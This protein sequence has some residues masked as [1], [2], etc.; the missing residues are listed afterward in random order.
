MTVQAN[1]KPA[2]EEL[3]A[4]PT[5]TPDYVFVEVF[6]CWMTRD[7]NTFN[8]EEEAIAHLSSA[9]VEEWVAAYMDHVDKNQAAYFTK[10][11]K[12]GEEQRLVAPKSIQIMRGRMRSIVA[13]AYAFMLS[14]QDTDDG[15]AN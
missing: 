9:A 4:E 13:D 12:A 1:K 6:G 7:G 11:P 14:Q 8:S 15:N 10:K 3:F 5:V 2:P